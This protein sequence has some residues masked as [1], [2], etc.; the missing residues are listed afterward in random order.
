M[1]SPLGEM[2]PLRLLC[3]KHR[4]DRSRLANAAGISRQTLYNIEAGKPYTLDTVHKIAEVLGE[5]FAYVRAVLAG[6]ITLTL[7]VREVAA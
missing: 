6:E 4:T 7:E 2:T 5:D 3:V 1:T